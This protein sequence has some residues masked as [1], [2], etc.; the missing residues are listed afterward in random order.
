[1]RIFRPSF[2]LS[3]AVKSFLLALTFAV[4]ASLNAATAPLYRC[5]MHPSVTSD[6][7]GKC[8]IC[9]MELF[10]IDSS[11]PTDTSSVHLSPN[12]I[13]TLGVETA[14][15]ARQPL[16]R[17]LR[18]AGR[19]DDD[20]TRHRILAARVPGRVEK[21][22]INFVGASVEA[23]APLAT[24][25]SPEMLSAQR[26]YVERLK[27]GAPAYSTAELSTA[28][29]QLQSLGLTPEDLAALEQK[30][31]P[32]ATVIVRAPVAGTVVSKS[33]Y[34]GQYVQAADRLF[35]ISDFS[36]MWFVFDAY[37][38]DIPWIQ[39]GQS[40]ELTTRAVPGEVIHT[41]IEF[42]DPNFNE[43][44]RTTKVRATLPNPHYSVGGVPHRLPHRVLAEG[45]VLVASPAVLA[46]PRSAILDAGRGPVAYIENAKGSYEPRSV[47][48][49]RSGDALV[50][51]LSGLAEGDRVVTQGALLIDA[52]AQ[53]TL[54]ASPSAPTSASPTAPS[55]ALNTLASTAIDAA[56]ALASDD[57]ARYQKLFPTLSAAAMEFSALPALQLG[58]DIKSARRSFE[59]WST[60]VAD[61]LKPQR[62]ALGVK[63]F[64]CPMSPV[65]K[66]GRWLQRTQPVKNPF[67]GSAM[68]D[69][70]EEI[71]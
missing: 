64:Q 24:I 2:V 34:E 4:A 21:L 22:H 45:R 13:T 69:C 49:G 32:S 37:E 60:S 25:Y 17:T 12:Q 35:E 11:A 19:I 65:L 6:H 33:V 7:P 39:V 18:V 67:F 23:G 57:Y 27:A 3:F 50:E 56:D 54:A 10:A 38:Q 41:T 42:I 55:V 48:V 68:P 9:G 1:M 70:G 29:E 66:K 47:Q 46:A 71:P 5:P 61:F 52:Q 44:T 40:L 58:T 14:T 59:P 20:D 31:E 28:R 30:R 53:L 62:A 43:S 16:V 51:V 36:Q 15:I 8:T 63:I 26:V